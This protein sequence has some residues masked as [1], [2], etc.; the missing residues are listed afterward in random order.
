[1]R[2]TVRQCGTAAGLNKCTRNPS[3]PKCVQTN[4][5]QLR[6]GQNLAT[7]PHTASCTRH[8][9]SPGVASVRGRK[10]VAH[11]Q[12]PHR[13]TPLPAWPHP[14]AVTPNRQPGRARHRPTRPAR[15]NGAYMVVYFIDG[16]VGIAIGGSLI[17][18]FGWA[19]IALTAAVALS[20]AA[21]VARRSSRR[22]VVPLPRY[23]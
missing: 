6:G 12:R 2:Q 9:A 13:D 10:P 20:A 18:P 3:L 1:M 16:S 5:Q 22:P 7:N 21:S 14:Q 15:F 17:R 11:E 19:A 23:Q 4:L 8:T